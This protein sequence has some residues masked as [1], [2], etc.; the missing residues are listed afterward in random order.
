LSNIRDFFKQRNILEVETPLMCSAPVTDPFLEALSV[1][2]QN[3]SWYFQTSP[4]YA[5]KRLLCAGSGSIYQLC[6][7]FR[8]DEMGRLHHP[9]FTML[10]WYHV[11]FNHHD[12]MSEMDELLQYATQMSPA[13]KISYQLLFEQYFN[14][15]PHIISD[16]ELSIITQE[17]CNLRLDSKKL[18]RDDYLNLLIT[19]IIEPK[20]KLDVEKDTPVF[21]YDYPA[22]QSALAKIR[23][24]NPP[25]A[26]RFEVYIQGIELANGYHE[27]TDGLEQKK[28]FD[29]DL[30][31]RKKL[32]YPAVPIDNYLLS[33]LESG[34]PNCAGVALGIDRLIMIAA[35]KENIADIMAF[36]HDCI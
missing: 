26:E 8:S 33:A 23:Q 6:K 15:N 29:Q 30:E 5:M 27:L 14:F 19:H 2:Y 22:S 36:N 17:K 25:V 21:I 9:E 20:L 32:N 11:G 34:M 31:K 18:D 28:R 12:L 1:E 13:K 35:Q 16:S 4:E 24:D 7:A 3:K 10:E